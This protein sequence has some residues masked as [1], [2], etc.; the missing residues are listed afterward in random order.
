MKHA[1]LSVFF[2]VNTTIALLYSQQVHNIKLN[3]I[4]GIPEG[5]G[6]L[7]KPVFGENGLK[8]AFKG[9]LRYGCFEIDSG[10]AEKMMKHDNE[11]MVI[12]ILEGTGI[13]QYGKK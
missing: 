9:I 3:D 13:L 11:E 4:T 5:K 2:F 12:F 1:L 10:C 7:C 6:V 8:L